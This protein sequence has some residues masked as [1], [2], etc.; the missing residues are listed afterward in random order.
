MKVMKKTSIKKKPAF[1]KTF[2]ANLSNDDAK[3]IQGG[4]S[5]ASCI[6]TVDPTESTLCYHC[7]VDPEP[8][9][10]DVG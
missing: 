4:A 1:K 10:K 5:K 6:P 2:V 7:P 3:E 9:T 8:S